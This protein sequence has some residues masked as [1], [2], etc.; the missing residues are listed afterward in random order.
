[1]MVDR[2]VD[3][4][5]PSTP[6]QCKKYHMDMAAFHVACAHHLEIDLSIITHW[7][8][9]TEQELIELK[10]FLLLKSIKNDV[11]PI[12]KMSPSEKIEEMWVD[13]LKF[14]SL[15]HEFCSKLVEV[16]GVREDDGEVHI[17]HYSVIDHIPL[18]DPVNTYTTFQNTI[19]AYN[20]FF[21]HSALGELWSTPK[22]LSS[23]KKVSKVEPSPKSPRL[24]VG[25]SSAS[26]QGVGSSIIDKGNSSESKSKK[27]F[28]FLPKEQEDED[29][30]ELMKWSNEYDEKNRKK[31]VVVHSNKSPRLSAKMN[32]GGGALNKRGRNNSITSTSSS[33]DTEKEVI[34][35]V[36]V[37]D[38]K[39]NEI[40]KRGPGRP[41]KNDK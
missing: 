2:M 6:D 27:H 28:G 10:R 5:R 12:P 16:K 38:I 39:G 24:S 7:F 19:N 35:S 30:D 32:T 26:L 40:K 31:N 14:P 37:Q 23:D 36:N 3:R 21:D 33:D 4:E 20:H 15:Y 25:Q 29:E 17:T 8:G 34:K 9:H 22:F 11:G 13:F 1:M 41:R 18:R